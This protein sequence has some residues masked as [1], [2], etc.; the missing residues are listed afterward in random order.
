MLSISRMIVLVFKSRVR[1]LSISRM[2]VLMLTSR[3][4]SA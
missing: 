1:V 3:V 4:K 2:M